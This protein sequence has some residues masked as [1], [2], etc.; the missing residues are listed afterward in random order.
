MKPMTQ[1]EFAEYYG[2]SQP[3]VSR[4]CKTGVIPK[5]ALIQDGRYLKILPEKA[6]KY[7][8]Q[9]LNP[10]QRKK[11]SPL[12]F[13]LEEP[14]PE[15]DM[16]TLYELSGVVYRVVKERERFIRPITKE[17]MSIA[18]T[19]NLKKLRSEIMR[20][21]DLTAENVWFCYWV[22]ILDRYNVDLYGRKNARSEG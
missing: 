13:L 20:R 22:Q 18:Q 21:L 3:L 5:D 19:G 4:Y 12:D 2:I 1:T 14:E 16:P 10:F 8:D 6:A 15:I 17:L 7:L 9:N 11:I